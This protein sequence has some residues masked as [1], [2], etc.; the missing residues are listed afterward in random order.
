[1]SLPG[2]SAC[3]RR[4]KISASVPGP[5]SRRMRAEMQDLTDYY[6]DLKDHAGK[7]DFVDLLLRAHELLK[8]NTE[9]RA[10]FQQR[11]SHVFVDD[12]RTPT[13]CR[14]RFCFCC[15]PTIQPGGWLQ[16]KPAPGKLFLVA[17]KQSI[18][19]FDGRT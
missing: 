2:E 16:I 5:I 1:M 14:L 13:R 4:S 7:L 17:T 19:K 18:Y 9:V 11:F 15:A 10:Y 6:K 8:G 3:W 12:F